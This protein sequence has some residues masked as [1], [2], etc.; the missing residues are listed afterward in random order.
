MRSDKRK[1]ISDNTIEAQENYPS[2]CFSK[3]RHG[4]EKKFQNVDKILPKVASNTN[5]DRSTMT[6]ALTQSKK[7]VLAPAAPWGEPAFEAWDV[8]PGR[9]LYIDESLSVYN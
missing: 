2:K 3:R 9:Q 5:H 7:Q 4:Q 1:H 8:D 6:L